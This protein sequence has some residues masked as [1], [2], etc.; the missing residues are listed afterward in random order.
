MAGP[1]G[2]GRSSGSRRGDDATPGSYP[3]SPGRSTSG[4]G[5]VHAP[6]RLGPPGHDLRNVDAEPVAAGPRADGATRESRRPSTG[7]CDHA[8]PTGRSRD[9]RD[10]R[11]GPPTDP[12]RPD[13]C[14]SAQGANPQVTLPTSSRHPQAVTTS[15][16]TTWS[17]S[18]STEMTPRA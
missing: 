16:E 14:R 2:A 15:F 3:V 18:S 12:D 4:H 17:N 5:R 6:T 11:S 8:A 10:G 7:R 9:G 1:A 13:A